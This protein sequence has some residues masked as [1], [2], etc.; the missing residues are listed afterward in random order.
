MKK[1]NKEFYPIDIEIPVAWGE[2]DA[3]QHVNN[4]HYFRYFESSRVRYIEEIGGFESLRKTGVGGIL[5][6]ADC[7]Y[8]FPLTYPDTIL[9]G[10]KLI[11]I[12]DDRFLLKHRIWSKRHKVI[13]A[14]GDAL[15]VA[16]DY[17]KKEKTPLPEKM[18]ERILELE[19]S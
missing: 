7:R 14:E 18:R 19:K 6:K 13:A 4:V 5:A 10:T 1:V 3:F 16:Y 2:M 8:K 15:V 12:M 17:K 11:E 9:V